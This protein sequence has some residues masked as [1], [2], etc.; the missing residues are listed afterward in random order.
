[1]SSLK[2]QVARHFEKKVLTFKDIREMV[3]EVVLNEKLNEGDVVEGIFAIAVALDMAYDQ[4]QPTM[5]A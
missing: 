5:V 2:E 1:M 3:K 4:I